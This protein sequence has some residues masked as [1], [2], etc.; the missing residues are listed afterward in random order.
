MMNYYN[1]LGIQPNASAEDIKKAYRS[2]AAKHHPDRGGDTA[3]FQEIQ[4]A[5]ETLSDPQKR[6]Q[7]DNPHPQMGGMGGFNFDF[8][9][10][11]GPGGFNPFEEM[12][13]QFNR[14]ARQKIY[15]VAVQVT[16]EQVA[17]GEAHSV[18][19][20]TPEGPRIFNIDIPKGIEDGAQV[21][22]EGLMADGLLQIQF[23][24]SRH[25]TFER[26][27]F[28]LY[29]T[30]NINVFD[31]ILGTKIHVVDIYNNSVEINIAP[32]TRPGSTLRV[33]GRGLATPQHSGDLY[34]LIQA[35]IPD[36]ISNETIT[37]LK[38]E[39]KRI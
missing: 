24:I 26:R 27:G 5:Y 28:D 39:Q 12:F 25:P 22:Y 17:K 29:M 8:G 13:R 6:A 16:L 4:K 7:Y 15:T 3:K 10:P 30:K 35:E 19:I 38:A 21:R 18:H 20:Q 9:G 2:L 14:H 1:I 33:P 34:I 37:A 36:T 32:K 23:R 31:I 11:G